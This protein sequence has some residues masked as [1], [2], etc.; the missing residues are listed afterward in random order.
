MVICCHEFQLFFRLPNALLEDSRGHD[1][2]GTQML[3]RTGQKGT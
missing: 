3:D 1:E 2:H